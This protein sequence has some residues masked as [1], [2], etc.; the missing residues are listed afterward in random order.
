M[1]IAPNEPYPR[2]NKDHPTLFLSLNEKNKMRFKNLI[3]M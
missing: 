3:R 2:L 1:K